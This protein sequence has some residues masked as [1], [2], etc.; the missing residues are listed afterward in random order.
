[1][2]TYLPLFI[3]F[4]VGILFLIVQIN[5]MGKGNIAPTSAMDQVQNYVLG[6]IIGGVIYNNQI[7]ALDFVVVLIIWTMLVMVLKLCKEQFRVV[8]NL[9]DGK[10][11]ALVSNGHVDAAICLKS[12]ISAN[13]LM[14]K[15]RSQGIY[16]TENIK[17]AILEQDGQLT[18]VSYGD[19]NLK[20][21]LIVDGQVDEDVLEI[22]GHDDEWLEKEAQKQG[23]KSTNDIFLGQYV[24]KKL[25]LLGYPH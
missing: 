5:I 10:P 24:D 9:V 23:F 11:H 4:G 20:L 12:G 18:V 7:S 1:M 13:D 15:L 21:P 6:G 2:V 25:T 22:I 19:E 8:K 3:K 14:F 17:K 16:T